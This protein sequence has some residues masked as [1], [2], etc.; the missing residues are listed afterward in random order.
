MAKPM[1]MLINPV[2]G[3]SMSRAALGAAVESF[4]EAGWC[5]TVYYTT[6]P[7][8]GAELT[9]QNGAEFEQLVCMGGDGTL[10]DVIAGLMRIP[11]DKRPRLGYIPMGTANDVASTLN[12][13]MRRPLAA[14]RDILNGR[15]MPYD[16]GSMGE[17]GY[18]T[19]IA[20]FG[21]FTEI[22]YKTDQ[23]MKKALGH[24]A[25]VL[26]GLSYLP[27]IKSCHVRIEYDGGVLDE[28]EIIYGAVSNS[29]SIA[30]LVRLDK[31]VVALSDGRFELALVRRPKTMLELN[32]LVSGILNQDYEGT[33]L[34][35]VPTSF[36][37]FHF[38]EPV[39]WTRDGEAGGEHREL[40]VTNLH[41]AVEFIR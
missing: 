25:Y 24:A 15:P 27:K 36:A 35:I 41:Q 9:A 38:D 21:A 6:G 31:R 19:Y 39:A 12:L 20:A 18:F 29:T 4:C 28:P 40:T 10:S 30:G 32:G 26:S 22:S 13:P 14:A 8:T 7:R 33:G 3:R 2:A 1:M 5:P 37:R 23:E 11:Q 16:V 34:T 17:A